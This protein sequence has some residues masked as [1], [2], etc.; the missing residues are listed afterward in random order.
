MSVEAESVLRALVNGARER[1]DAV[2]LNLNSFASP[3]KG[4]AL[5]RLGFSR[6]A[7]L[8]FRLD[9]RR[10]EEDLWAG[11]FFKRRTDIRKAEK[12]G[13]KIV[14][15]MGADGVATLRA[16][17]GESS[18][19]IVQRGGPDIRFDAKGRAN[20]VTTLL[21][22][23]VGKPV[24][25]RHEGEIVSA[26]LF[27]VFNETAYLTLAG[28]SRVGVKVQAPTYLLWKA[29]CEF[30]SSGATHFNLGGCSADA[31]EKDSP[32]H[33]V[34][35]YKRDFGGEILECVS[36]RKILRPATRR[37]MDLLRG[38]MHRVRRR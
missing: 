6:T 28:H 17:Q 15:L 26:C 3:G 7:R 25:A 4:T 36:G 24:G 21:G 31:V 18:A 12:S 8:E 20:P 1:V 11:R 23:G 27:T 38:V 35:S 32:E 33:G 29:L 19:R 5:T 9:L 14:A 34:Y 37:S 30:R 13:V 22:S 2:E 16:L 10:T